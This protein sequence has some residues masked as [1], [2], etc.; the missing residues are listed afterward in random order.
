MGQDD[1]L[2]VVSVLRRN[3]IGL[4]VVASHIGKGVF[5]KA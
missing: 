1:K 5:Q 2:S 4:D 3:Y